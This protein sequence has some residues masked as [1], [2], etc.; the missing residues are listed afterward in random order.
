[1]KQSLIDITS[2]LPLKKLSSE[3]VAIVLNQFICGSSHSS[4]DPHIVHYGS[5]F[6]VRYKSS[7]RKIIEISAAKSY[8][9]EKKDQVLKEFKKAINPDEEQIFSRVVFTSGEDLYTPPFKWKGIFQLGR[10]PEGNPKPRYPMALHPCLFQFKV[11]ITGDIRLDN[12]RA[13]E[14]FREQ[15]LPLIPLLRQYCTTNIQYDS[16]SRITKAWAVS[17]EEDELETQYVQLDYFIK[18]DISKESFFKYD[19]PKTKQLPVHGHD[20]KWLSALDLSRGYLAYEILS[21]ENKEIFLLGCEW[22]NKAITATDDTDS[23]LFIMIMLE[24]FLPKDSEPCEECGQ[25]VYSINQKF[26][27]Y[28]PEVIGKNWTRD[29]ERTLGKL[30]SLRSKIA[31]QGT[32][33]AQYS[34]GLMPLEIKE[35]KQ[36]E[37]AINLARQFLVSWLY[38]K[39]RESKDEEVGTNSK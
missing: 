35:R 23:F 15:F 27:T 38:V 21:N 33:L 37:Y 34:S 16:K 5:V 32:A 18:T 17:M 6:K 9:S 20:Y 29:F 8:W 30:Y 25:P 31:H 11:P 13:Q 24:I 36:L 14:S 26:K 3:E 1:M 7:D 10:I 39:S 12:Y 28:I 22:F 19:Q 4:E 2:Q